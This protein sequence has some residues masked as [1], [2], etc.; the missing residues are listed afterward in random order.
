LQDCVAVGAIH[1]RFKCGG[2]GQGIARH[3]QLKV[4]NICG[5]P[6]AHGIE[7]T[8][9]GSFRRKGARDRGEDSEI[10]V[11]ESIVSLER[12]RAMAVTARDTPF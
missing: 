10:G 3:L 1:L 5:A 11:V 4:R 12:D 9:K 2:K 6:R 8:V 7:R